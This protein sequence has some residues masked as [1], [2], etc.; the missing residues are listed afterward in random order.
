MEA[1]FGRAIEFLKASPWQTGAIAF[2]CGLLL[3]LSSIEITP[4]LNS[5]LKLTIWAVLL[6]SASLT[7]AALAESLKDLAVQ[8]LTKRRVRQ[9]IKLSQEAFRQYV[10]FLSDKERQIFGYL[11]EKRVKTFTGDHDGGYAG[12]LIARGFIRYA[13]VRGQTFDQ[14]KCPLMVPDYV[15]EVLEEMR[16]D[17]PYRPENVRG[18]EMHPWRISWMA[19]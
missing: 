1:L 7:L 14:D 9:Q 3:F 6:F 18:G 10:P 5:P 17:F 12:T 19:R 16:A 13:G 11:L 8:A 15:W 4:N 2:A